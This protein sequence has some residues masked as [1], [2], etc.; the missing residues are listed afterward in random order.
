MTALAHF[1]S[2]CGPGRVDSQ[3]PNQNKNNFLSAPTILSRRLSKVLSRN[4]LYIIKQINMFISIIIVINSGFSYIKEENYTK[5]LCEASFQR[6][7]SFSSCLYLTLPRIASVCHNDWTKLTKLFIVDITIQSQV[8]A[9]DNIWREI[10]EAE[11][12]PSS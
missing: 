12:I 1:Q 11:S 6:G 4:K 10:P 5:F 7:Y 9:T 3:V 8:W 2:K